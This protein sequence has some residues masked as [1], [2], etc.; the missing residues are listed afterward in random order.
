MQRSERDVIIIGGGAVAENVAE[1][2]VQGGLSATI[3]EHQLVGGECSFWACIPSKALLRPAQSLHEARA[4][5]GAAQA[6]TGTLDVAAV[7]RRRDRL[8]HDWSDQS[9]VDWVHGAALN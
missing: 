4:V 2:A 8:V 1:R 6:V 7:L 3:V 5:D 9:Q